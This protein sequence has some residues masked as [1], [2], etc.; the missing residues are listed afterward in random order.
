MVRKGGRTNGEKVTDSTAADNLDPDS[1]VYEE[2]PICCDSFKKLDNFWKVLHC[3]HKVCA[4]CFK[5][6]EITRT[7]MS[8]VCHTSVKCPFCQVISGVPIGTCPNGTMDV[9]MIPESCE[10]Y[11]SFGSFEINY[12]INTRKY[13]LHRIAYLPNNADGIE[14]LN[15]LKIAW[16]R[17][18]SFTIGTSVTTGQENA[19]VWNIHHKTC[20][21]GGVMNFGYPDDTY[22]KR[23]K[24]ELMAY[25]IE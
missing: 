19:V 20:P 12:S 15:L 9:K 17:R 11:E 18:I 2:C 21:Y 10:G 14:V 6:I 25:G 22:F 16:D 3:D 7:T 5:E 8:G 1:T 4:N 13:Y 24:L 23:V